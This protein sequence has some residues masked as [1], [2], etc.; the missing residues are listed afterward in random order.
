LEHEEEK[1]DFRLH[2][3]KG[4]DDLSAMTAM[5]L[6]VDS[7]KKQQNQLEVYFSVMDLQV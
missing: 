1:I 4:V 2:T 6:A 5:H 3:C 7:R